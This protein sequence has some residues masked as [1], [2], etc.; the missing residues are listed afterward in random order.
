MTTIA[1]W[2]RRITAVESTHFAFVNNTITQ[3][4]N[5]ESFF[6]AYLEEENVNILCEFSKNNCWKKCSH[7][8]EP[9]KSGS[10]INFVVSNFSIK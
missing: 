7:C 4:R 9:D 1:N 10:S 6:K 3:L 5:S 2:L 8:K